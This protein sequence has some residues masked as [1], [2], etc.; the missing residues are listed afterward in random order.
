MHS[1]IFEGSEKRLEVD[2]G[3]SHLTPQQGLRCLTR[4]QLDFLLE[5]V[6]LSLLGWETRQ[7]I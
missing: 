6:C 7:A 1:Q 5:K 2:F 3:R 4:E